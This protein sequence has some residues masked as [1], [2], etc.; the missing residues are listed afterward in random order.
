MPEI[1]DNTLKQLVTNSELLAAVAR[2]MP[3][4]ILGEWNWPYVLEQA[5]S[6]VAAAK[7]EIKTG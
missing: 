5:E 3:K 1:S 6:A 4:P 2:S 7:K